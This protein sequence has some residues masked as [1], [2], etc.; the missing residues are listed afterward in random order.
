MDDLTA[1]FLTET[2]ESLQNLEQIIL[3]LESQPENMD[4]IR[5]AFRILH[6]V[7]GTCGFL[8]FS[9]MQAVSHGAENVLSKMRDGKLIASPVITSTLFV[10]LDTIRQIADSIESKGKESEGSDSDLLKALDLCLEEGEKAN[11]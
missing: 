10:A 1:D 5:D 3:S 8:G 2:Y 7:K 4:L 6:T 9:R 11:V